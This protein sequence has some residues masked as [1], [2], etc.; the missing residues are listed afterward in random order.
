MT[1]TLQDLQDLARGAGEI[2]RAGFH[3]ANH[4][5]HKGAIDLVTEIDHQS[6]R[7]L[8][9]QISTRFPSHH[10]VAEE[11]GQKQGDP[12]HTWYIDPLDGTTNFAHRLPIFSVSIAYAHQNQVTLGVVYD[13]I[14]DELFSADLGQGA[15][16]NGTP[17]RPTAQSELSR[18]L[19]VTGFPYDRFTNPENNL[20]HMR[21][22]TLRVQ[23]IRRLGSAA[24]DLCY[25]ASGRVDG[26]WEIKLEAWD[27]AA[28]ALIAREAGALVSKIDGQLDLLTPPYSIVAANPALHPAMLEVLQLKD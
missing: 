28:G 3:N 26:Y 7:Y 14:R 12:D 21:R 1:P 25:I 2:L 6:E 23:G 8:L 20:D 27:L 22:F 5:Q 13:P 16:L 15:A 18:S 10:I 11:T 19:V 9:E 17:I 4:I 24:L